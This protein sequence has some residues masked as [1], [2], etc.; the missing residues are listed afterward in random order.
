VQATEA[1]LGASGIVLDGTVARQ[2]VA[3]GDTVQATA[4]I[5]NGGSRP[6]T[7]RRVA[8]DSRSTLTVV[9][10]DSMTLAA[11]S[12]ARWS[13]GI[14]V[15]GADLHWWQTKGLLSG[16]Y[17]HAVP[18]ASPEIVAGEDRIARSGIEATLVVAGVDVPVLHRPLVQR[19]PAMARGDDRHPLTG[20]TALSVLLERTAE[21]ERTGMPVDRLFR[22]FLASPKTTPETVT[23]SLQ[24][25]AGLRVDSAAKVAIVPPL[26]TRNV[27]FRLR[28]TLRPGTDSISASAS[29]GISLPARTTATTNARPMQEF[30]ARAF[31]YGSITH[32]YPHIPSQ[33]FIRSSKERLEAVDLKVPPRLRV[34]YIKGTDDVQ[35][36]LGQLQVDVHA[37][38]PSLVSVVDLAYYSTILIGAGAMTN[39][40][41]ATG[42]SALRDFMSKGGAVVVMAG[43]D[44]VARSGLLPFPITFDGEART[45]IDPNAPIRIVEPAS[46][47]VT[48]PNAIKPSDFD[49]WTSERARNLPAAFDKRYR[50]VL[51]T[52]DPAES[53]SASPLLVAP[54][55]RGMLVFSSLSVDRELNAV[56]PGAA[57]LFVNLMSAGLRP[58][59]PR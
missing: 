27:F 31:N 3:P 26:G 39:D 50:P 54:V 33:Q 9:L 6:V 4:T 12:V 48:W 44:E 28:G 46:Q 25:P 41:L 51:S 38:D 59:S 7:L 47:L 29:P 15:R 16:T 20:V 36:A 8:I 32:E 55:G 14:T 18:S 40:A 43:G 45:V 35:Q 56:H 30:N 19:D 5:Y 58:G 22:V 17:L 1:L 52:D 42:I 13:G 34:A 2:L 24:V 49:E 57:R 37:L 53:L 23:V 11:D 10:R 21:Y